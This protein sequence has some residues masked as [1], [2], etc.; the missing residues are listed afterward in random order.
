MCIER[1]ICSKNLQELI[2]DL[3]FLE[4]IL[5]DLELLDQVQHSPGVWI[6]NIHSFEDLFQQNVPQLISALVIGRFKDHTHNEI[7][8]ISSDDVRVTNQVKSI[9]NEFVPE[10]VVKVCDEF[11]RL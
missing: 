7:N 10:L 5:L 1:I 3:H 9:L 8:E 11:L 2:G 4:F 6:F